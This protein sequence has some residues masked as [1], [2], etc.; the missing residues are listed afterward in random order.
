MNVV[1]LAKYKPNTKKLNIELSKFVNVFH[2]R[3]CITKTHKHHH[4]QISV[5]SM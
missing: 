3:S 1:H 5:N 2:N 4:T